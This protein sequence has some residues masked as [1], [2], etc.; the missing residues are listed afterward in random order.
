MKK[1]F[2][3]LTVGVIVLSC[4]L[5][6]AAERTGILLIT[7]VEFKSQDFMKIATHT[8]GKKHTLS[9]NTQD[10][11]ATYCWDKGLTDSDPMTTKETLVDFA[12]TTAYDKVIFVI[13]KEAVKTED[14]FS[15]RTVL[16]ARVV[17]MTHDGETLKVFEETYTDASKRSEL[18]ANL[19]A[20]E[21]LCK[22]ISDRLSG[23]KK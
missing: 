23:K 18:R 3:M 14:S 7:P 12:A 9:Q 4:A 2:A 21:G 1:L 19:G 8:F 13:F 15:Y 6:S 20:F 17:I 16:G 22:R 10:D 11:W 5:C